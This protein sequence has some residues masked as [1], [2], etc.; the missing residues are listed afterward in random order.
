V[1]TD[2]SHQHPRPM[3]RLGVE[4]GEPA[5]LSE[6]TPVEV[7]AGQRSIDT[8]TIADLTLEQMLQRFDPLRHGGEAM[9]GRPVGVEA[10]D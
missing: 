10:I 4:N 9:A 1:T 8:E 6:G 3:Q 5:S 7:N 2:S